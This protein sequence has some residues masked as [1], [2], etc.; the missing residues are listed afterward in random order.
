MAVDCEG[1]RPHRVN[2][3][4][5][6]GMRKCSRW[7][8]RVGALLARDEAISILSFGE[9][10]CDEGGRRKFAVL[11]TQRG[12]EV[13]ERGRFFKALQEHQDRNY[14]E[15]Q[16]AIEYMK[17]KRSKLLETMERKQKLMVSGP[18][19]HVWLPMK[20]E[21]KFL[22]RLQRRPNC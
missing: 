9:N 15:L 2:V 21:I 1:T 18:K 13:A 6:E 22:P 17:E 19:V 16:E 8:Y 3:E 20:F 5:P 11:E 10:A 4:F 14:S 12:V 7:D